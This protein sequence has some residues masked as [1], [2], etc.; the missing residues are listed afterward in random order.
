L[1]RCRSWRERKPEKRRVR[2][3]NKNPEQTKKRRRREEEEER[4]NTQAW[5]RERKRT[6]GVYKPSQRTP[7]CWA[8]SLTCSNLAL[9]SSWYCLTICENLYKK[10]REFK[11]ES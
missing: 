1:E 10:K 7:L 8:V 6:K 2:K 4:N 9:R 5:R 11:S 3:K